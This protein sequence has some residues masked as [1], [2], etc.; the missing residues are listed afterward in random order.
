LNPSRTEEREVLK[1]EG[2]GIWAGPEGVVDTSVF[3]TMVIAP[4]ALAEA[5]V[6]AKEDPV[7]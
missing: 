6:S 5:V 3:R 2:D 4:F 1:D 7:T